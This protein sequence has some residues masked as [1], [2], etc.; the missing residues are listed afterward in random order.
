[1]VTLKEY[2]DMKRECAEIELSFQEDCDNLVSK[3][4][5]SPKIA[6]LKFAPNGL[7]I[8]WDSKSI[9][10]NVIKAFE[11]Q[12]GKIESIQCSNIGTGLMINFEMEK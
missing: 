4:G 8:M 9:S 2:Y 5:F 11:Q 7:V 3:L 12:F 6:L 10:I 1:M